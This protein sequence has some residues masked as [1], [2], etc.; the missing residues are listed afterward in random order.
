MIQV[1]NL[2]LLSQANFEVPPS[3]VGVAIQRYDGTEV[4][5]T[6]ITDGPLGHFVFTSGLGPPSVPPYC[7]SLP[8]IGTVRVH[9]SEAT[10]YG[11]SMT[12]TGPGQ[13]QL[14]LGHELLAWKHD[15]VNTEVSF[16]GL[17]QVNKE[18]DI[19]VAEA[20]F[21]VEPTRS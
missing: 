20:T 14:T 12:P 19:A 8:A 7:A 10:F 3:Y 11:C 5:E 13:L 9:D 16:H 15:G 6:S 17:S 21:L 4:P 1:T 18:L 2:F